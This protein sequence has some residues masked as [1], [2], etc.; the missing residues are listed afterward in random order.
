MF[1]LTRDTFST[2]FFHILGSQKPILQPS[3]GGYG[4]AIFRRYRYKASGEYYTLWR[5]LF[6]V[7]IQT[8]LEH[9]R[10]DQGYYKETTTLRLRVL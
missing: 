3:G 1:F 4:K 6:C 8:L 2:N 9:K 5:L 7:D 10:E